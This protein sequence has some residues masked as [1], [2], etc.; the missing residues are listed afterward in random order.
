MRARCE[1]EREEKECEVDG[2]REQGAKVTGEG[3]INNRA[4]KCNSSALPNIDARSTGRRSSVDTKVQSHIPS[5]HPL[6]SFKFLY[7]A[8]SL[9][10]AR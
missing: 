4:G 10:P 5:V 1:T 6:P 7:I 3:D 2:G 9:R 8:V